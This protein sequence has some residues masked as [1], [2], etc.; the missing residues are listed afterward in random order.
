MLSPS[1][2]TRLAVKPSSPIRANIETST[3]MSS[4]IAAMTATSRITSMAPTFA[5]V[6]RAE[7]P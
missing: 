1:A 6:G 4:T 2:A 5:P 7:I 3:R